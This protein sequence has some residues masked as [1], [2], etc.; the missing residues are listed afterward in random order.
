MEI[1][2]TMNFDYRWVCVYCPD[3]QALGAVKA[4]AQLPEN[5][6]NQEDENHG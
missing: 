3:K 2:E 6:Y 4:I 5:P 1:M